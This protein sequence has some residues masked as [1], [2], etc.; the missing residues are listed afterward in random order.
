[1][2]ETICGTILVW[3]GDSEARAGLT[4]VLRASGYDV[5]EARSGEDVLARAA[6]DR[7]TA[8][9]LDLDEHPTSGFLAC[10]ILRERYGDLLPI[11][12]V[13]G[14]RVETSDRVVGLLLGADDYVLKP[15]SPSE[16]VARVRRLVGRTAAR[17][18]EAP[19]PAPPAVEHDFDLTKRE[20]E[21][22]RLLLEGL[23][24]SDIARELVISP[25]TVATHIQRILLK[26]GVHNRAQAVAKVAQAGW[27][28][29]GPQEE[30]A[31]GAAR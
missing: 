3:L 30:G 13:S 16:I 18:A 17:R 11:V 6:E 25:N 10:K 26:L 24:Q 19:A 1:M 7:P 29:R 2:G 23:T 4:S 22:M 31:L 28:E 5:L 12:L 8:V 21:V 27:L 14:E 9:L 20:R 15:F